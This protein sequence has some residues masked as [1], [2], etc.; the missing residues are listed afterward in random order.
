MTSP[1]F[2]QRQHVAVKV[3]GTEG[4]DS[5]P[6]DVDV[7]GPAYDIEYSPTFEMF[8][9]EIVQNSFSRPKQIAGERSAEISFSTE[10]KGEGNAG[11]APPNLSA[12][13]QACGFSETIVAVT[14]VTY[15]P[16]SEGVSSVTVEIR[17]GSTD[18]TVKVKKIVGARGTVSFEGVKGDVVLAR[19]VFT[20]RYVE[21]SDDPTT[22]FTTPAIGPDP[23]SFL[24][25][26]FSFHGVGTT[27]VQNVTLDIGNAVSLRNDVNQASGN[28]S[29]IIVGRTPIGSI[30]PEQE[31]VATINFFNKLT[32]NAE[33]ILTYVL[34]ASAGNITTFS[35]PKAQIIGISEADR[36]SFRT[37]DLELQLNQSAAAGDDELTIAFT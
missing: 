9:R 29:A 26:A 32:T 36:D 30:D 23:E 17:E 4:T 7:I 3:E 12:A 15:A 35:A 20:G 14:S 22:Q 31:L 33:G 10:I 11:V 18:G 19:F 8:A 5:V 1:F 16:V 28:F 6:A 25:A 37:E 21:P 2:P 34:G 13:L 27:K 24:G